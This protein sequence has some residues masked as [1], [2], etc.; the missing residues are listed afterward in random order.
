MSAK[1]TSNQM[2][3]INPHTT[4]E[5]Y[6]FAPHFS[7][8]FSLSFTFSITSSFFGFGGGFLLMAA[9]V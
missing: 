7:F 5:V 8:S 2:S 4:S 9:S 6:L 1:M 3:V